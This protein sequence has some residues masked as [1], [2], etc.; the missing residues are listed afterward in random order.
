[1][2]KYDYKADHRPP[3]WDRENKSKWVITVQNEEEIF[4][5]GYAN[6]WKDKKNYVWSL[7]IKN[8]NLSVIGEDHRPRFLKKGQKYTELVI[9]KFVE[10]ADDLWHGY[11]VSS[12]TEAPPTEIL[13]MWEQSPGIKKNAIYKLHKARK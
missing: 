10:H 2:P 6:Q 1:M 5:E 12:L 4:H 11:P 3:K 7:E 9:A 13:K 8:G